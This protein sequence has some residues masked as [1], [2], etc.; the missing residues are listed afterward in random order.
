MRTDEQQCLSI[1]TV[2]TVGSDVDDLRTR[3]CLYGESRQV[4]KIRRLLQQFGG[5]I[6]EDGNLVVDSATHR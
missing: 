1:K 6:T 5:F 2:L 3:D 4:Y